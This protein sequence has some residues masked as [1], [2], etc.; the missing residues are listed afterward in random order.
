MSVA[1]VSVLEN[2]GLDMQQ[3]LFFMFPGVY[4]LASVFFMVVMIFVGRD[5]RRARELEKDSLE[6]LI[7]DGGEGGD[8]VSSFAQAGPSS[9]RTTSFDVASRR[10][11]LDA[12]SAKGDR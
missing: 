8:Q 4:A 9:D 5:M 6:P 1:Q 3:S 2:T 7:N 12:Y 10:S 11:S